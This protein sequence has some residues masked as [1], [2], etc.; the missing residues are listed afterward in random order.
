MGGTYFGSGK[1]VNLGTSLS[2]ISNRQAYR[3]Q[4]WVHT[5]VN[6]LSRGVSRLPLKAYHHDGTK[7]VRI[8]TRT[9]GALGDLARVIANPYPRGNMFSLL[10][11]Q[12]TE[13]NIEGQSL[14][15]KLRKTPGSTPN[16][17]VPMRADQLT[18]IRNSMT[19]RILYYEWR[20]NPG[21]EP[22]NLLPEDTIDLGFAGRVSPLDAL[23]HTLQVEDAAQRSTRAFYENGAR[24]SGVFTVDRPLKDDAVKA[25]EQQIR[26]EH[27]GADNNFKVAVLANVPG[28]KWSPFSF[29]A[30]DAET[31]ATRKL[32]QIEV[33]GAYDVPPPLVG[34]LDQASFANIETQTRMWVVDTL[35]VHTTMIELAYCSHLIAGEDAWNGCY[36]E[37]DM[38]ELLR[39]TPLEQGE[40]AGKDLNAA[41]RTPNELRDLV[42]LERI[43]DP[44]ADAVYVPANL[45]PLGAPG[46][47]HTGTASQG[48]GNNGGSGSGAA[49]N[50]PNASA[51]FWAK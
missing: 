12:S 42:N 24:P 14:S 9:P 7:R 27:A 10:N 15:V 23:Q 17:I 16:Q 37:F 51:R 40:A 3:R 36:V 6:K 26:G 45:V 41:R 33:C 20:Q 21:D 5:V 22:V 44:W 13:Y 4:V 28:A 49:A 47:L 39:G 8:T 34:I 48:S 31:I 30:K 1:I 32:T 43:N 11:E 19:G 38:G 18:R 35:A 25:L 2:S 50:N 46:P 29:S